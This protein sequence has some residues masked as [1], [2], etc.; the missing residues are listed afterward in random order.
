VS[1]LPPSGT[2]TDQ[3][4]M[5]CVEEERT[6]NHGKRDVLKREEKRDILK[7]VKGR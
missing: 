2:G 6:T 7:S 3:S 5:I 1:E 4:I